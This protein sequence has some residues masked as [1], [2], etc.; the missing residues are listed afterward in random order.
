MG[1]IGFIPIML[2]IISGGS[3]GMPA[4]MPGMPPSA[5]PMKA[6][7]GTGGGGCMEVLSMGFPTTL[8]LP[9]PLDPCIL[10]R[11]LS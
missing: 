10:P 9:R 1:I 3:I 5:I 6:P 2:A 11:F 8:P 7:P 4:I